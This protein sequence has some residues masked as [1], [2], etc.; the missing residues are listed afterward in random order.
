MQ[1]AQTLL[2]LG[3][4]VNTRCYAGLTALH[5]AVEAS[6]E[7]TVDV[8]L[9]GGADLSLTYDPDSSTV[10]HICALSGHVEIARSL[11]SNG[12]LPEVRR[13]VVYTHDMINTAYN[14][15]VILVT[16][17]CFHYEVFVLLAHSILFIYCL[18]LSM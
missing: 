4:E 5:R 14:Y 13:C 2:S 7:D 9:R 12:A 3:A 6:R 15:C 1:A 11:L 16:F 8:L 18:L 17:C 10:L